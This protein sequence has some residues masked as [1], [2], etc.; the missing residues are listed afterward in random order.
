M[1]VLK[2]NL[3]FYVELLIKLLNFNFNN[4]YMLEISIYKII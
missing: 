1:Y 2:A 4:F 3:Y